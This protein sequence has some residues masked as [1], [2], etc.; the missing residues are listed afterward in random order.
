MFPKDFVNY[1][2]NLYWVYRVVRIDKIKSEGISL[3]KDYWGCDIVVK[4]MNQ[5]GENLLFLREIPELEII[6]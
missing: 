1:N 6:G 5:N 4:N 2:G 3:I